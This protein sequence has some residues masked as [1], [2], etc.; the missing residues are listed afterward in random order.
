MEV[1]KELSEF[2]GS[3]AIKAENEARDF[4]NPS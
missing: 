2:E 1:V 4:L 3:S